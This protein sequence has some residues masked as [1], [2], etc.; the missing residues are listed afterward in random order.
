M[1]YTILVL[2]SLFGLVA[3]A[4][5]QVSRP[6]DRYYLIGDFEASNPFNWDNDTV[7]S[8]VREWTSGVVF[9]LERGVDLDIREIV[10]TCSRGDVCDRIRGGVVSDRRPLRIRFR[11]DLDVISISVRSKPRGFSVPPPRVNVYLES[12][13][14]W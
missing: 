8:D 12:R 6:H 13:S 10:I 14:G 2:I 1:K 7:T 4:D 11:R 9:E 5:S 3:G